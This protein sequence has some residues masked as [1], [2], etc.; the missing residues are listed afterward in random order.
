MRVQIREEVEPTDR[1]LE[2]DTVLG[3]LKLLVLHTGR[4]ERTDIQEKPP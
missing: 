4:T 2:I 1:R 3:H